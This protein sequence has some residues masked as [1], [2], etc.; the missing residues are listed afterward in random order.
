[1]TAAVHSLLEDTADRYP[2]AVA[3][4]S[5]D[6]SWS[7]RE[8]D[9]AANAAAALLAERGL[10]AGDRLAMMA[11]NRPEFAMFVYGALKLGSAA[12]MVSPAWK[13]SEVSH[14]LELTEPD[15]VVCDS[16]TPDVLGGLIAPDSMIDLDSPGPRGTLLDD[17]SGS[18]AGRLGVERDWESA[19]AVL[20]FSS[21]TT[22]MPKAVRHLHG[23]LRVATAHWVSALA[24]GADDRIQVATPPFHILGL[25]NLL[26]AAQAGAGVR[27]H[28]RFDLDTL[29]HHIEADRVTIE[30]VVAPIALGLADHPDL[31][32]YDLSSLRYMMWGATPV[33]ESIAERI[34]ERTGVRF[35]PGYGASEVPVIA[36]NPVD[37][38]ASWRLDSV[39]LAIGDVSVRVVD[40]E[41]GAVVDACETG[42]IQVRSASAMA[43]YLPADANDEAFVDGWYRTGDVGWVEPDGW[44]HLTDRVKEM[45]KVNAFQ[46]APAEVEAVL[47]GHPGVADCAVF[48]VPDE[49]LGEA[50]V[51]AV[52]RSREFEVTA[53]EL[54]VLVADRLASYKAI[55]RV[56]FVEEVPRLPSGKVLRRSLRDRYLD[57]KPEG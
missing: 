2:D 53:T 20:V 37:R 23:S 1:M 4:R 40:L 16:G 9:R 36:C 49:R 39:G 19:E 33:T 52:Q 47:H 24:L 29:L 50:V 5:S 44:L 54:V 11:G 31:E 27:I 35:M 8:L 28:R 32:S 13:R 34:T 46:V 10:T 51:A 3:L 26:A 57:E 6:R 12:V 30:M 14:A 38:P 41:S 48:G 25:L 22:G 43:G 55:R 15:M 56:W 18:A 42:E 7:F 45:I 17:L 21:G